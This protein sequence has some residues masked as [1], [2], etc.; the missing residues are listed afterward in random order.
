MFNY[1]QLIMSQMNITWKEVDWCLL[2]RRIRKLQNRIFKAR[3]KGHIKLVYYLQ[4]RLINSNYAKLFAVHRIT[5]FNKGKMLTELNREVL[6]EIAVKTGRSGRISPDGHIY[7]L[8]KKSSLPKQKLKQYKKIDLNWPKDKMKLAMSLHLDNKVERRQKNLDSQI[9]CVEC[10]IYVQ[11]YTQALLKL[12]FKCQTLSFHHFHFKIFNSKN[13]IFLFIG[14]AISWHS[15]LF[16]IIAT[17][18]FIQKRFRHIIPCFGIKVWTRQQ[19]TLI[20]HSALFQFRQNK[21][22]VTGN[23]LLSASSVESKCQ[24]C[25]GAVPFIV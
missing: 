14:S 16:N 2:S 10:R 1:Q 24:V 15:N 20:S 12:C 19:L 8:N 4:N 3:Q 13:F 7:V 18:N 6:N 17:F 5:T 11:Q 23:G 21:N 25:K 22:M 9:G